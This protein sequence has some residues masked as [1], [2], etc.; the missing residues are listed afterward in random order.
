M[1]E[2]W[3]RTQTD[4]TNLRQCLIDTIERNQKDGDCNILLGSLDKTFNI[5]PTGDNKR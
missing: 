1:L 2:T 5:T 3:R 4:D